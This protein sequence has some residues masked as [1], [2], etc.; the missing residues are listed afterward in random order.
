MKSGTWKRK[1]R[2]DSARMLKRLCAIL[3]CICL[4]CGCGAAEEQQDGLSGEEAVQSGYSGLAG[5][6]PLLEYEVEKMHPY[7]LTDQLGYSTG[8][9]K[10]AL[11]VGGEIGDIYNVVDKETGNTVYSGRMEYAGRD[12]S[13]QT[14]VC[15]GTFTEMVE[16]GT[17]YI[18]AEKLGESYPFMIAGEIYGELFRQICLS[19]EQL[20]SE[21]ETY[22]AGQLEE[23]ARVISNLL[24]AY[25]YYTGI[26]SDDIGCSYSGNTIP[27]LLDLIAARVEKIRQLD[28]GKL[29][30]EELA[31]YTGILAK[32]AQDY[33]AA[34]PA[35]AA[36]CLVEAQEAYTALAK[37]ERADKDESLFFYAAAELFRATGFAGYHTVVRTYL[38]NSMEK[39]D[40]AG[41]AEDNAQNAAAAGSAQSG[42][43]GAGGMEIYG[44]I[45]YLS[46]KYRVDMGLCNEIIS[47]LMR[48]VEGIAAAYNENIYM[49]VQDRPDGMFQ[50]IIKLAVVNY[51]ITN[52]EY[53]TVQEN[54]LH[55]LLGRNPQ[56][57]SYFPAGAD[58]AKGGMITE[59]AEQASAVIL[60]MC[61]I[62]KA[63]MEE[64]N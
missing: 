3:L 39:D 8:S 15:S 20:W 34:G 41:S 17:Y 55:Y 26:F 52:H 51:V 28:I 37:M 4:I 43:G 5:E 45:A 31:A 42:K 25:E 27:D 63:E 48:E 16:E 9:T 61:E 11:F 18:C 1:S 50:D 19:Y 21:K 38:E 56:G 54:Q 10:I 24:I 53:V 30:Y 40:A 7:V 13:L 32:F 60:L 6:L 36:E 29:S 62:V 46:A 35:Q 23:D 49:T 33:K 57:V 22:H 47:D 59:H 58:H 14:S 44:K 64:K 2:R 12:E